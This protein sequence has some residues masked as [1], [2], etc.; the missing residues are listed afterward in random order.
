[1]TSKNEPERDSHNVTVEVVSSYGKQGLP[2][3]ILR[4]RS[5][6]MRLP[7]SLT[8]ARRLRK[9]KALEAEAEGGKHGE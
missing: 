7:I 1:M 9:W 2:M 8:Q 3:M 6:V 5:Q 4:M